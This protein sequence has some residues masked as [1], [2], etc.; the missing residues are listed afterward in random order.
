MPLVR[1]DFDAATR[2]DSAAALGDGVHRALVDVIAIPEGDRFQILTPHGP[3]ELIFDRAYL[4]VERED[5]VFVHITL[6]A[7]RSDEL[8]RALYARIVANLEPLGVRPQDVVVTL[9]ENA[10][11]DWSFGRGET[12]LLDG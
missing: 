3:G 10:S 9:S 7:G 2:R 8:K 1:I 5:A 4:G 11:S 6:R 12:Q